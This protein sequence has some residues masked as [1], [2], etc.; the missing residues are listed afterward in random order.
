MYIYIL[1]SKITKKSYIGMTN[2]I[3]R[4]LKEHNSGKHFYTKR[5]LPWEII[6]IEEFSTVEEARKREKYLKSASGRRFLKKLFNINK[7]Y[8]RVV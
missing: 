7:D 1:K 3:K 8:C 4:R 5:Y 6:H 2:D